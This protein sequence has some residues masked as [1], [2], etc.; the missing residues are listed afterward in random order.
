LFVC[1]SSCFIFVTKFLF[2]IRKN[3]PVRITNLYKTKH[4]KF[5][6]PKLDL[7]RMLHVNSR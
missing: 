1:V 4:S 3:N 7:I 5:C 6:H 2:S